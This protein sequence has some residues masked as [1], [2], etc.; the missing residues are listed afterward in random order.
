LYVEAALQHILPGT[1]ITLKAHPVTQPDKIALIKKA[2]SAHYE[3]VV[4][5]NDEI[6]I[7]IMPS[8]VKQNKIISFSYSSVS[9]V[10]LYGSCVLH[11]MND[12]LINTFF[13]EESRLWMLES[14]EL[15][16]Q[17]I[18]VARCLRS[19]QSEALVCQE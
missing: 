9:L 8:L 2:L 16:L 17:Q 11:A 14:N 18:V 13:P 12:T 5:I 7:E 6:P 10:Y 19:K 3:T 1:K 4:V 15:Y